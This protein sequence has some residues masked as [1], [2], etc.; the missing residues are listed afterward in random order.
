MR[1]HA[2][3]V[4]FGESGLLITGASGSGKSR[5]CAAL[6]RCGGQLIADDQTLLIAQGGK[7]IASAPASLSGLLEL[8]GIGIVDMPPE[9]VADA[10]PVIFEVH[11]S[12]KTPQRLPDPQQTD[13]LGVALPRFELSGNCQANA[14]QLAI[15]TQ[16]FQHFKKNPLVNVAKHGAKD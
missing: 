5:L 6:I 8:Y 9:A 12:D 4:A 13:Y 14:S 10:T 15:L 2:S 16:A 1:L 3:A 7:L 11:L